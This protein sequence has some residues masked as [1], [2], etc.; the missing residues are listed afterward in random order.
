MKRRGMKAAGYIKD[1][2]EMSNSFIA[3]ELG[4][5]EATVRRA[6]RVMA[7]ASPERVTGKDGKSYPARRA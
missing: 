5:S 2:F 6:R 7:S 4:V 1:H 3:A